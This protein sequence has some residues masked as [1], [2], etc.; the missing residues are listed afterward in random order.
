[1]FP[2]GLNAIA[3]TPRDPVFS[4]SPAALRVARSQRRTVPSQLPVMMPRP[5]AVKASEPI[6]PV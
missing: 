5:S 1:M 3:V 2:A 4:T 6:P